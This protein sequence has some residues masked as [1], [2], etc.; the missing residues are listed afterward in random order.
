[1]LNAK[2]MGHSIYGFVRNK[3]HYYENNKYLYNKVD[4]NYVYNIIMRKN[5]SKFYVYL[6]YLNINVK[7]DS[8]ENIMNFLKANNWSKGIKLFQLFVD[9]TQLQKQ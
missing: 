6:Q 3:D 7:K 5:L 4:L 8:N 9:C 1:M 2:K